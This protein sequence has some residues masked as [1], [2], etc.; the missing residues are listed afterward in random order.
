MQLYKYFF[1]DSHAHGEEAQHHRP[2]VHQ[3]Q[4]RLT[5]R[6]EGIIRAD[7]TKEIVS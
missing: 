3:D 2:Q 7:Q 1:S 6:E 4:A 5:E